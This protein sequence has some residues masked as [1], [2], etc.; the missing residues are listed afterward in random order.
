M[1]SVSGCT[2]KLFSL[3]AMSPIVF[4]P[5]TGESEELGRPTE[6]IQ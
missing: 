2:F 3:F 5:K 4:I 1:V 6:R